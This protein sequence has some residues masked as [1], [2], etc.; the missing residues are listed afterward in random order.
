MSDCTVELYT[1]SAMDQTT[2]SSHSV[3]LLSDIVAASSVCFVT[4]RKLERVLDGVRLIRT[5]EWGM[6]EG[7]VV[8]R[9]ERRSVWE[10]SGSSSPCTRRC[11]SESQ[12]P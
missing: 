12:V 10:G 9:W 6:V 7:A 2:L 4:G 3:F 11:R 5:Y 8:V 1:T